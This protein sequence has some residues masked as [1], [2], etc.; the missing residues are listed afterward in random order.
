M[1][2]RTGSI[3]AGLTRHNYCIAQRQLERNFR[4]QAQLKPLCAFLPSIETE[5]PGSFQRA[6][7]LDDNGLDT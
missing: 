6:S 3:Y 5:D 4:I 7:N 2:Q 1:M